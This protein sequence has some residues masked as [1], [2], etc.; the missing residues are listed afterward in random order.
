ME[1]NKTT[2]EETLA[3][4]R[5][6]EVTLH[7]KEKTTFVASIQSHKDKGAKDMPPGTNE[8]DLDAVNAVRIQQ[9]KKPWKFNKN[10]N[11]SRQSLGGSKSPLKYRYCQ[12]TGH[13]KKDCRKTKTD[14]TPMV[15]KDGK[16]YTKRPN[17]D[18]ERQVTLDQV[19]ELTRRLGN[20]LLS[21]NG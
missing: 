11:N 2:M 14:N 20:L 6:I 10:R 18:Q 4:A 1:A 9:G 8:E 7:N 12:N 15:D 19:R 16:P 3:Y 21:L 5:D 17:P 13:I